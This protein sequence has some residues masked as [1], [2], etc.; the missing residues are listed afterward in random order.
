MRDYVIFGWGLMFGLF[1]LACWRCCCCRIYP[2]WWPDALECFWKFWI[3]NC[4]GVNTA[5]PG[6]GYD[7]EPC[8]DNALSPNEI[9]K[10]N[11]RTITVNF[12]R[13]ILCDRQKYYCWN[14]RSVQTKKSQSN[15]QLWE[16]I[17]LFPLLVYRP[18]NY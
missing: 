13:T 11:N 5:I 2:W 3:F 12:I 1:G 14:E 6:I 9:S 7:L 17:I 15:I 16:R 8:F 4:G 18:V 10:E